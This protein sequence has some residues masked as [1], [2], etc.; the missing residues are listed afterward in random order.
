MKKYHIIWSPDIKY[1]G[2]QLQLTDSAVGNIYSVASILSSKLAQAAVHIVL[3]TI[4]WHITIIHNITI[5]TMKQLLTICLLAMATLSYGQKEIAWFDTGIK[6]MYGGSSLLNSAV[7]D[8]N[9][10]D[11][12]LTFGN[13]YSV[14]GKFGINRGFN[15]LAIELLY[16]K[17]N[18]T[19]QNNRATGGTNDLMVDWTGIDIYTLFRN[20]ANLG[21]FELG[22]KFSLLQSLERIDGEG[23]AFDLKNSENGEVSSLGISGV[24]SM[25][26]LLLGNDRAF[27]GQI[28]L[29][30]EYGFTDIIKDAG[31]FRQD[32]EP[33][34]DLVDQNVEYSK[35]A[36]IYAG[37]VFELNFGLGFYG[38]SQCGGRPKLF[39][40]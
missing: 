24:L 34:P 20:N 26:V 15:G 33:F 21:F 2:F 8:A 7:A 30:F 37:I 11:Y 9:D 4:L 40:F 39:G 29:R 12:S 27:S 38:I 6:V 16:N 1:I 3:F 35:S 25:G 36:P 31:T 18:A 22:P 5:T 23:S 14:G 10:F 19:I 28:G 13:S 17:G 32:F